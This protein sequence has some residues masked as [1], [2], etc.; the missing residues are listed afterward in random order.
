MVHKR[1]HETGCPEGSKKN[2]RCE[3]NWYVHLEHTPRGGKRFVERGA[4]KHY[5]WLLPEAGR[6]APENRTQ[7]EDLESLIHAW[8]LDGRKPKPTTP[9]PTSP[10]G[11]PK[12]KLIKNVGA[13]YKTRHV[14][15]LA[16]KNEPGCINRIIRD[17]GERPMT[18]L[19]V[20][21]VLEEYLDDV[22]DDD[23]VAARNRAYS[24]L[25]NFYFFCRR[26][27]GLEGASP[28][29]HVTLKPQGLRELDEHNRRR[30][31]FKPG[32][33]AKLVAAMLKLNDGG[34][35]MGRFYCATDCGPRRG[36]MLALRGVHAGRDA[37]IIKT[38]GKGLG[39]S[40]VF[41]WTTTKTK[42]TRTVPITT[43]RLLKFVL[44]RKDLDFPF[45]N[46]DGSR[47]DTFRIDWENVLLASGLERGHW[48]ENKTWVRDQDADLHWHDL[49]HVFATRLLLRGIK[50]GVARISKLLGHSDINMTMRY[51]GVEDD[52]AADAMLE[53]NAAAGLAKKPK[54]GKARL[55]LVS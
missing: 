30:G 45:G 10:D 19:L 9:E 2:P 34:M 4:M 53:V 6:Q 15:K 23:K 3:H 28:F 55:R 52:D 8:M 43:E 17:L 27:H 46:L 7:A 18:D 42:K 14:D 48:T 21:R 35:M 25:K 36:E 49:R 11:E 37:G 20:H 1:C 29:Y 50:G 54:K 26:D 44:A 16:N 22:L 40:L 13:D 31:E 38:P 41:H 5:I 33:E 32:E 24:R 12:L 47:C 39:W 51:L